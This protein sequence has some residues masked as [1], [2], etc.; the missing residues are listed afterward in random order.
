MYS[1]KTIKLTKKTLTLGVFYLAGMVLLLGILVYTRYQSLSDTQNELYAS[2]MD[3]TD[4]LDFSVSESASLSATLAS[5]SAELATLQAEDQY[6]RNNVLEAQIASIEKAYNGTVVAY[7]SL[8]KLKELSK[9]TSKYDEQFTGVITLLADRDYVTAETEIKS[10]TSGVAAARQEIAAKFTI[11]ANV[12]VSN[13][14]PGSGYSRQQ[15][16]IDIGTYLVSIVSADL[17]STRVVVDTASDGTC[18]NDCPVLPLGTYVSRSGAFAGI[19]GPYFCPAAYPSCAGKTN[20]FDTLIMN[21]NKVYFNSDNNVYSNVPAVIFSGSS[22]RFV[23]QTSQWGRDTG[24]DSVIAAQPFL[25]SGGN[26]VFGGDGDPKKGS[27]GPRGFIGNKGS[28][29]YI[30]HVHNA[31]VAES[32]RVLQGL[33]LDNALNL[34]GGG[35]VALWSGGYKVGPGRNLPFGILLVRK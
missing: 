7:E 25:V 32:A 28:T 1:Y 12:P 30:G 24:V 9:D 35:S 26:V 10:L 5:V 15:V 4:Q 20:S 23:G 6:V 29:V 14:P 33:G 31:T 27:K 19:N 13:S 8:L 17:N 3:L 21:K 11:P 16:S 18:G 2:T 34:D 22:A